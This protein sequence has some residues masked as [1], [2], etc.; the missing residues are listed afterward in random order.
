MNPKLTWFTIDYIFHQAPTQRI[1]H[2]MQ[3]VINK[4]ELFKQE[5]VL[6]INSE[7][8]LFHKYE[9]IQDE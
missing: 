6:Y 1:Q 8:L 2:L 4:G 9:R 7:L 3:Q 5:D